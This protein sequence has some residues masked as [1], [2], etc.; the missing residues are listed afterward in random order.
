MQQK[1]TVLQFV[2]N[3]QSRNLCEF[4]VQ[5]SCIKFMQVLE[6]TRK[7]VCATFVTAGHC[8]YAELTSGHALASCYSTNVYAKFRCTPLCIKKALEIFR[9]LTRTRRRKTR[10]AFWDL[11]SGFR[12]I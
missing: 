1:H 6:W 7:G 5:V 9:E 4:F 3:M 10:V 2:D 11:R 8:A 12:N